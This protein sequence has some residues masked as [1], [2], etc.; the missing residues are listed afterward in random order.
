MWIGSE[1]VERSSGREPV[2]RISEESAAMYQAMVEQVIEMAELAEEA[3]LAELEAFGCIEFEPQF[4]WSAKSKP[5]DR[6]WSRAVL[7]II[8]FEGASVAESVFELY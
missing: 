2:R 3:A 7:D 6:G 5:E 1:W 4:N 8:A